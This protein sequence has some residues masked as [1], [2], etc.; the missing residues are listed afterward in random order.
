MNEA[1]GLT[2]ET[3]SSVKVSASK[4]LFQLCE[5]RSSNIF[6]DDTFLPP[7]IA[8]VLKEFSCRSAADPTTR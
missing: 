4:Q 1:K 7:M 8:L 5:T 6:V 2:E 3:F